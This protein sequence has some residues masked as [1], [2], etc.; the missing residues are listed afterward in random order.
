VAIKVPIISTFDP[1][2]FKSAET[3]L[4]KFGKVANAVLLGFAA[5]AVTAVKGANEAAIAQSKLANVLG[6]MGYEKATDRVAAYAESLETTLAIDADVIKATQTKLATFGQLTKTVGEAGGAFDR[7]TLAALDL[8][9][10]G[11]GTAEGN[12]VSLGKALQDPVKGISALSRAGV[13]FTEQEKE[14]IKTLVE[15]N[16]TLEAQDMILAAIE[17]QVGGTAEASADDFVKMQLAINKVLDAIGNALL[18]YLDDLALAVQNGAKFFEEN[19]DVILAFAAAVGIL[20][21]AIKVIQIAQAVWNAVTMANPIVLI[22][23]AIVAMI[24]ALV[25]AYKRSET[26]RKVVDG[27]FNWIKN[28]AGSLL[29]FFKKI[30]AFFVQTAKTLANVITTPYRLA[31]A[32]IAK[33][34]NATIGGLEFT[35]PD[36]LPKPLGGAG[37]KIPRLPE[38]IPAL[39]KGGIVNKPTLA[40]IGEAGPEAVVPLNGRNTPGGNINITVNGALDPEGVARSIERILTQSRRRAGAY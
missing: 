31:F 32:A 37:I 29:D 30:P 16:K 17:K 40:L 27:A 25:I 14:K 35:L 36:W 3:T 8:A 1:K 11:F 39:A 21:A 12:A 26:F 13:T 22:V 6:S 7:A 9:A 33:L 2:G 15:S 10:A 20:A 18:P 24:A 34:W 38:G 5:V 28:A 23:V 4:S 19:K